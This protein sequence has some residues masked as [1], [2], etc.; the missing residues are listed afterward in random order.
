MSGEITLAGLYVTVWTWSAWPDTS[1]SN[2]LKPKR[3][4]HGCMPPS[5]GSETNG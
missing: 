1:P 4:M 5:K 3:R 2:W